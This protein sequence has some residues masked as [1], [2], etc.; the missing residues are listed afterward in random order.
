MSAIALDDALDR[1]LA[2][3]RVVGAVVQVA[4]EGE[5]VYGRA[6]GLADRESGS[7]MGDDTVFR[8]SSLSKPICT[9]A[10]MALVEQGVLALDEPVTSWL[11]DFRPRMPSGQQPTITVHHLLT[12]TAGL[13]AP[14]L[15]EGP[16]I[17]I[18]VPT[19]ATGCGP[20]VPAPW[21]RTRA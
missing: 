4:R 2:E 5:V 6:A 18:G 15:A 11:P 20:R 8:L 9:A 17:P 14:G 19:L 21:P 12:H 1:A 10:V 16:T 3:R 13:G 7:V